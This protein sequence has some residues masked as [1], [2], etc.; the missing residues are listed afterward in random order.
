VHFPS[1]TGTFDTLEA[2]EVFPDGRLAARGWVVSAELVWLER[3]KRRDLPWDKRPSA[4]CFVSKVP[5]RDSPSMSSAGLEEIIDIGN[6][7]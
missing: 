3:L 7:L 4:G 1:L 2:L 6:K 5:H